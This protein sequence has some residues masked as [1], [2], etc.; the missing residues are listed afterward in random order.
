MWLWWCWVDKWTRWSWWFLPPLMILW[1][2][3]YFL[4]SWRQNLTANETEFTKHDLSCSCKKPPCSVSAKILSLSILVASA[5]KKK[6]LHV[7]LS[8]KC[9]YPYFRI[10]TLR[11]FTA[12]SWSSYRADSDFTSFV[13]PLQQALP[14]LLHLDMSILGQQAFFS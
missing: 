8:L 2:T 1:K 6:Y 4:S 3:H 5:L 7:A 13:L 11:L 14:L 9:Y 12:S 10:H